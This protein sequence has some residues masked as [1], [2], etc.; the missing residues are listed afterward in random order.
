M[1]KVSSTEIMDQLTSVNEI[2]KNALV[3]DGNI[4]LLDSKTRGIKVYNEETSTIFILKVMRI[5]EFVLIPEKP[6]VI[7]KEIEKKKKENIIETVDEAISRIMGKIKETWKL[8]VTE[9]V[10]NTW[11]KV[12]ETIRKSYESEK[13]EDFKRK[14]RMY[15]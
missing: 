9:E 6:E 5:G 13:Y 10:E 8:E 15:E 11:K 1:K 4:I 12:E 7:I 2:I 14:W 3:K